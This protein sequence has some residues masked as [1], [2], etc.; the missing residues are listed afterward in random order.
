[1]FLVMVIH[2][3][4]LE[5]I[6]VI[7]WNCISSSDFW[8]KVQAVTGQRVPVFVSESCQRSSP[9]RTNWTEMWGRK[10]QEKFG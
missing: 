7:W 4:T 6:Y 1:M 3:I 9:T 10:R 8:W 5:T 2:V